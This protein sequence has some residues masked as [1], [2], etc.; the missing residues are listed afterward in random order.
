MTGTQA[1]TDEP[2][3]DVAVM[4]VRLWEQG[5]SLA[6]LVRR[7]QEQERQAQALAR[8]AE[9]LRVELTDI[10]RRMYIGGSPPKASEVSPV[11]RTNP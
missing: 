4:V 6:E 5:G 2:A 1:V 3:N 7:L 9:E 10:I 11:E 8:E